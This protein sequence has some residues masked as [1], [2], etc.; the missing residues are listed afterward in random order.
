MLASTSTH[1]HPPCY[2]SFLAGD[3]RHD[4]DERIDVCSLHNFPLDASKKATLGMREYSIDRSPRS[5]ALVYPR[6]VAE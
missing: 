3:V 1:P 6:R 2:V 5:N 4:E